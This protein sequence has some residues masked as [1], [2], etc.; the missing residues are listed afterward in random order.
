MKEYIEKHA[1]AELVATLVE[2]LILK[3]D[4]LINVSPEREEYDYPAA[5]SFLLH[6]LHIVRSEGN[7]I[8]RLNLELREA[9]LSE[10]VAMMMVLLGQPVKA[11]T[12]LNNTV[13][14]TLETN[15]NE[16]MGVDTILHRAFSSLSSFLWT[17]A[18]HY[19]ET[20]IT[21]KSD[22]RSVCTLKSR[23]Y[24]GLALLELVQGNPLNALLSIEASLNQGICR[25]SELPTLLQSRLLALKGKCHLQLGQFWAARSSFHLSAEV[26]SS[27]LSTQ[28]GE[29][30]GDSDREKRFASVWMRK[31]CRMLVQDYESQSSCYRPYD[32]SHTIH[33]A[34]ADD[35]YRYQICMDA[36]LDS[37]DPEGHRLNQSDWTV[38]RHKMQVDYVELLNENSLIGDYLRYAH[39]VSC[40]G[41][42][43]YSSTSGLSLKFCSNVRRKVALGFASLEIFGTLH[44]ATSQRS[45]SEKWNITDFASHF[46]IPPCDRNLDAS[47]LDCIVVNPHKYKKNIRTMF[48]H[49]LFSLLAK[50]SLSWYAAIFS[51]DTP[52]F[53]LISKYQQPEVYETFFGA[54]SPPFRQDIFVSLVQRGAVVTEFR[55]YLA[56]FFVYCRRYLLQKGYFITLDGKPGICCAAESVP[57]FLLNHRERVQVRDAKTF[58]DLAIVV[59]KS[60][61][62]TFES[63][64][65]SYTV[66]EL[67]VII[68]SHSV[69][70]YH[71]SLSSL[72][73]VYLSRP[74]ETAKYCDM[75]SD[76]P[77]EREDT[78]LNR[79]E[80]ALNTFLHKA[81]D[82]VRAPHQDIIKSKISLSE[83]ALRFFYY[84]THLSPLRSFYQ[85]DFFGASWLIACSTLLL[86]P[87]TFT[88]KLGQQGLCNSHLYMEA[89]LSSNLEKFLTKA[90]TWVQWTLSLGA[91]A[92]LRL[93]KQLSLRSQFDNIGT[94]NNTTLTSKSVLLTCATT[95][96]EGFESGNESN[97]VL[98]YDMEISPLY[99]LGLSELLEKHWIDDES[100]SMLSPAKFVLDELSLTEK[101]NK[102]LKS[103]LE[104]IPDDFVMFPLE[105]SDSDVSKGQPPLDHNYIS[106]LNDSQAIDDRTSAFANNSKAC[107]NYCYEYYEY[108]DDN[109]TDYYSLARSNGFGSD[110]DAYN[111]YYLYY[112]DTRTI[113]NNVDGIYYEYC[114]TEVGNTDEYYYAC[115]NYNSDTDGNFY[116]RSSG[117]LCC[118]YVFNAV[119]ED[120]SDAMNEYI[121]YSFSESGIVCDE[122]DYY[123]SY[124]Y[125]DR[126]EMKD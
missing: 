80:T 64:D 95:I 72:I 8:S 61:Y 78:I 77:F 47:G 111:S 57:I 60:F 115:Y 121:Y 20:L 2:A 65:P 117:D 15:K 19:F 90:Q 21:V 118:D 81:G 31:S 69:V 102:F 67:H 97:V 7:E 17:D 36:S 10:A 6:A 122:Q 101:G 71:R 74:D 70:Q 108:D 106:S 76:K 3:A 120:T 105:D 86:S 16:L 52:D 123:Y 33:A 93:E 46:S 110:V 100:L 1:A 73:S 51:V 25:G 85:N 124:Y 42:Y 43:S 45:G 38:T 94:N 66:W 54:P 79:L 41:I 88:P 40:R 29:S 11:L 53:N 62:V 125:Y 119:H 18:R 23:A 12:A 126:M 103:P 39:R 92:T 32:A 99:S 107:C 50:I 82:F 14:S 113:E 34:I 104:Y 27:V 75:S 98:S 83:S 58:E 87:S 9:Y 68:D 96:L 22:S 89:L 114:Y 35:D 56:R 91:G 24:G 28:S 48:T 44:E 109:G 112:Y 84:W 4:Q 116:D 5:L 49:S 30:K 63:I 37:T 55:D 13:T 26:A 59:N